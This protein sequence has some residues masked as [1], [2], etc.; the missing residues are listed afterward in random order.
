VLT[1]SASQGI[2]ITLIEAMDFFAVEALVSDLHLLPSVRIAG[3]AS[4]VKRMA[5]AAVAKPR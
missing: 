3:K 1:R 5:S 2:V 4:T